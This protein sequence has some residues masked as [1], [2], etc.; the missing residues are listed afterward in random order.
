MKNTAIIP[1]PPGYF[2]VEPV[3]EG[4]KIVDAVLIPIIGWFIDCQITHPITLF[5][6]FE[7]N[8][9]PILTP[10]NI[11]FD[12]S[13]DTY[14]SIEDWMTCQNARAQTPTTLFELNGKNQGAA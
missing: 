9:Y 7:D 1:A 4:G 12:D 10:G 5:Q 14:N 8:N 2:I 3:T 13:Q 6:T 11:V